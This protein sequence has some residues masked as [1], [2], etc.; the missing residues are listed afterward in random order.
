MCHLDKSLIACSLTAEKVDDV[1]VMV[2]D[3][4]LKFRNDNSSL[5]VSSR[6]WNEFTPPNLSNSPVL[7]NVDMFPTITKASS[8]PIYQK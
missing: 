8:A 6:E 7:T 2:P 1:E 3:G 5:L 4:A